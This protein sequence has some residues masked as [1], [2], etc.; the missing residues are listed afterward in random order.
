[1]VHPPNYFSSLQSQ[2][3]PKLFESVQCPTPQLSDIL[4]SPIPTES[5]ELYNYP[6]YW[7]GS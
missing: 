1:M 3:S 6:K 2:P 5:N 7:D 4:K